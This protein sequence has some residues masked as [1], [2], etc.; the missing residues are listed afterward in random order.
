VVSVDYSPDG[1]RLAS[2]GR[3][4]DN[5]IHILNL[6]TDRVERRLEAHELCGAAVRF[7]PDGRYLATGSDD[8][9]V[10]LYDLSRAPQ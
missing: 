5:H 10:R 4:T 1:K 9:S 3:V 2:I 6:A 7:S 8:A